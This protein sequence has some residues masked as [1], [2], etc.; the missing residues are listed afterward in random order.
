MSKECADNHQE[1][2]AGMTYWD[3]KNG[4][5]IDTAVLFVNISIDDMIKT[6]VNPGGPV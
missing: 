5:E 6:K 3:K 1:I 4:I 2:I